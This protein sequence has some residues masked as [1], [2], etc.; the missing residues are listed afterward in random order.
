AA[1]NMDRIDRRLGALDSAEGI[2]FGTLGDLYENSKEFAPVGDA[3]TQVELTFSTPANPFGDGFDEEEIVVDRYAALAANHVSDLI[4]QQDGTFEIA[5]QIMELA[6]RTA[7]AARNVA[8]EP[9]ASE[10]KPKVAKVAA[11]DPGLREG[12]IAEPL[13]VHVGTE[14]FNPASDPVL[15]EET[16][17]GRRDKPRRPVDP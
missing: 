17:V 4:D 16:S 10:E 15:P 2:E 6:R 1:V 9:A 12:E 7:A 8:E 11:F 5:D 13:R 14:T 3:G